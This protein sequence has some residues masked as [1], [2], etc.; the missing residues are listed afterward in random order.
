MIKREQQIKNSRNGPIIKHINELK[1]EINQ[2][3]K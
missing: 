3:V 1:G 2:C